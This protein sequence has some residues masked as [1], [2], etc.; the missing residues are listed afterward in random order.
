[1]DIRMVLNEFDAVGQPLIKLIELKQAM[2]Y[3][4]KD[5]DQLQSLSA[6]IE[7]AKEEFA[8]ERDKRA[9]LVETSEAHLS[10]LLEQQ[11]A[12][13]AN[14]S[15]AIADAQDQAVEI[16][17][18]AQSSAAV[19]E[20]DAQSVLSRAKV[21]SQH[22]ISVAQA[23][24]DVLHKEIEMISIE[25]QK[26]KSILAQQESTMAANAIKMDKFLALEA[27]FDAIH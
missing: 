9:S 22:T 16:V 4:F 26:G 21:D 7:V 2:Q 8:S 27:A 12:A 23:K 25:I 6:Q 13:E 15:K 18:R 1:M 14:I 5:V 17:R 19:I 10:S 24:T 20:E 3:Y 11:R